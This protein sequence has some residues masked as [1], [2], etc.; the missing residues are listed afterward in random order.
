M[1]DLDLISENLTELLTNS[2]NMADKFYDIFLNPTPMDVEIQMYTNDE[3][4]QPTTVTI[5][6]RAKDREQMWSKTGEGSPEGVVTAPIGA[7][8]IDLESSDIYVKTSEVDNEDAYG[9]VK[10]LSRAAVEEY[11]AE[12]LVENGY[13]TEST[14]SAYLVANE[15]QTKESM[16]DY[17]TSNDYVVRSD[18]EELI[19]SINATSS[20][21][22]TVKFDDASITLNLQDQLQSVAIIDDNDKITPLKV[23]TGNKLEYESLEHDASTVYCV[24]DMGRIFLG[25]HELGGHSERQIGEIVT[26]YLPVSDAGLHP[27]DGAQLSKDGIYDELVD[28]IANL[29]E[30]SEKEPNI[31]INGALTVEDGVVGG[32]SQDNYIDLNIPF[33][34]QSNTWEVVLKIHTPI[35]WTN[36]YRPLIGNP[37]EYCFSLQ[38]NESTG[39]LGIYLSSD[40]STWDISTYDSSVSELATNTD[41]WIKTTFN[42]TAYTTSI[43]T[44]GE[45]YVE[46][47]SVT[48]SLAISPS[49]SVVLGA[50]RTMTVFFTGGFIDLNKCYININNERVWDGML[51]KD[52]VNEIQWKASEEEY[53]ICGKFVYDSVAQTVRLPKSNS[54]QRYLIKKF[55][56]GSDWYRIYS[57]GWCEQGGIT[58]PSTTLKKDITLPVSYTDT[59]Y[60]VVFGNQ[61]ASTAATTFTPYVATATKVVDGFSLYDTTIATAATFWRTY[62]Y[63]EISNFKGSQL[64]EYIVVATVKNTD[65]SVDIDEIATDLNGKAEVDLINVTSEGASRASGWMLPSDKKIQLTFGTNN[66]LYTSPANGWVQCS[67]AIKNGYLGLAV[68]DSLY[69]T[70]LGKDGLCMS[71]FNASAS[72]TSLNAYIPVKKGDTFKLFFSGDTAADGA[73]RFEFIYSLGSESEAE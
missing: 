24:V 51:P 12:Y 71:N 44:D 57:D 56:N 39:K 31:S 7:V 21:Y 30:T 52:F 28:Y 38:F 19:D 17:L 50:G 2:V 46:Y 73:N 5:P 23:W 47:Q 18:A 35:E 32:F 29:Y 42:G 10:L 22:G 36:V 26:S 70:V 34:P 67:W 13:Q 55:T 68:V 43:S 27:L 6:N 60:G 72:A 41:Y 3:A 14:M 62:G 53:G 49:S 33:N 66:Q 69:P 4:P 64:Y 58:V 15:Y 25:D 65:V 8:Y 45:T 59:T 54:D 63:A 1:A 40:G 16:A 61:Y 37:G 20:K 11:I 9:W 48:S